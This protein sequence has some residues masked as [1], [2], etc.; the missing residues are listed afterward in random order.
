MA[1]LIV[2]WFATKP[3]VV[4]AWAPVIVAVPTVVVPRAVFVF[5][6]PAPAPAPAA[7]PTIVMIE[8]AR[9]A[10]VIRA[11]VIEALT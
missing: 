6:A 9:I 5:P 3:S 1:A 4:V 2:A 10:G 7:A 8:V 11:W